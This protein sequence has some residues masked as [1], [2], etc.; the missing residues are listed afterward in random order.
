MSRDALNG[1]GPTIAL[2]LF[3]TLAFFVSTQWLLVLIPA[4]AVVWYSATGTMVRRR[5]N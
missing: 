4:A 1:Y 2:L 3:G 5:R